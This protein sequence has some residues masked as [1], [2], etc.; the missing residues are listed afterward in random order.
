MTT[1]SKCMVNLDQQRRRPSTLPTSILV[2]D[3][4]RF[5][6]AFLFYRR[7]SKLKFEIEAHISEIPSNKNGLRLFEPNAIIER[8]KPEEEAGDVKRISFAGFRFR[9]SP[10]C[11]RYFKCNCSNAFI[12]LNAAYTHYLPSGKH[13]EACFAR[14]ANKLATPPPSEVNMK[15]VELIEDASTKD[16]IAIKWQEKR[17]RKSYPSFRCPCGNV[18]LTVTRGSA[19]KSITSISAHNKDKH[20]ATCGANSKHVQNSQK[21]LIAMLLFYFMI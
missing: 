15:D 16:V 12:R 5:F 17:W 20:I 19:G 9:H 2:S 18:R 14:T 7:C 1:I 10:A 3:L 4:I 8:E 6:D 21:T 11:T 13:T